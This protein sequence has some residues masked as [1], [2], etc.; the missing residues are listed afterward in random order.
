MKKVPQTSKAKIYTGCNVFIDGRFQQLPFAVSDGKIY[1][2]ESVSAFQQGQC[3]VVSDYNNMYVFPGFTDVHVHFREPGFSYKE[4]IASGSLA[5]AHGGYTAVC[6]MPNL[7]PAPDCAENIGQQIELIE[8]GARIKVYPYGTITKDRKGEVLSDME[9][10]KDTA[11][12][13]T[14]DGSG[15]QTDEL[16]RNAMLKAKSLGK[17]IAAH[18]EDMSLIDKGGCIHKGKF[19]A[20]NGF[21]GI[22]SESEWK[23]VERD[24]ALVRE[25]GC[26]YHVCHISTKET[27]E[28]IRKAKAEGLNVTCE[29]GPHYLLLS[30]K[31]LKDEG[32]FKM[33]PPLR[34]ESDK[35]ALIA[36]IIDGTIDM[37]ATDHAPHSAEEKSKGLAG[38]AMGVVGLETAFAELYTGLVKTGIITLEKLI[39]L[40][41]IAP[42]NRFFGRSGLSD[43]SDADF[44]IFDLDAQFT[45]DPADFKS[46]GKAT[47]FEGDEL[48][49]VCKLT[50][51]NGETVY[52]AK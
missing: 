34:D 25:I 35:E 6:T 18:C 17:M 27:V 19:A 28:L 47:P 33:N 51:C 1:V 16:M 30:D 13:F 22:S 15:I 11:I 46:M 5:A 44:C 4:T 7:N 41:S 43:G 37:I 26:A 48:Y 8:K 40:M 20:E 3:E 24:L 36:G 39:N 45:V 12:A 31:D 49:G 23:Q 21:V 2:G 14:D 50:V 9:S 52:Q 38:S 42:A 29:T 10:M 32:R